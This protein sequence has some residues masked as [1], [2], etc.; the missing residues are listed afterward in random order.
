MSNPILLF[1]LDKVDNVNYF[2]ESRGIKFKNIV[3]ED[4]SL[5]GI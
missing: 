2:I 3:N 5:F 4:T 1:K